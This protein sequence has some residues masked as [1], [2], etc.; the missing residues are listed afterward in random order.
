MTLINL[1]ELLYLTFYALFTEKC[2]VPAER[3]TSEDRQ[4]HHG[5]P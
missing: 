3:A 2:P 4:A 1:E 5:I